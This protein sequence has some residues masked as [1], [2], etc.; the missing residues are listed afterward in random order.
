MTNR[1]LKKAL[2]LRLP[3]DVKGWIEAEAAKNSCSQN[4]EII[5]AIRERMVRT[6]IES[7]RLLHLS[8]EGKFLAKRMAKALHDA[9]ADIEKNEA[10]GPC[11]ALLRSKGFDADLIETLRNRTR[12]EFYE[13]MAD[14]ID[15][16]DV[17]ARS[18]HRWPEFTEYVA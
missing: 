9:G 6:S 11:D 10:G 16:D 8:D 3:D 15:F 5:R 12:F 18:H 13:L 7:R 14:V 1:T 2:Q 4:S 17:D